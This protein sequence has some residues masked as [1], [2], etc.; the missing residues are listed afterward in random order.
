MSSQ[1]IVIVDD[2]QVNLSLFDALVRKLGSYEPHCFLDARE[3]L[4]WAKAHE[5]VLVIVDYMMPVLNGIEFIQQ[6]RATPGRSTV[7]ILMVTAN[8]LKEVRYRALNVGATDFLTKP[9]DRVEFMA[10][11]TNLLALSKAQHQLADR[12]EWLALE[13]R[14]A[15]AE[16]AQRELETVLRLSKAAEYRDPETGAHILRMA[17]YSQLIARGLGLSVEEQ[18]LILH[19]AP[20]HDIG[21]VGV[22]DAILLKPG[23]LTPEE[24]ELMK[25]HALYGFEI[26]KDSA[27]P[28]LQSGATIALGHHEKFDG[29]GYPQGLRGSAIP[30]QCRIV[31][32]ADVFDALTSSRPYKP[33]WTL[34]AARRHIQSQSGSHF[35]PSC[36]AVFFEH[37]DEVMEIRDRFRDDEEWPFVLTN[38]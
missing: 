26:L 22:V 15:T 12:A 36:V 4:A 6:L 20:L 14:K 34:E 30:L 7:P 1:Y 27:S 29:S 3:G 18:D 33:A 35:D 32:V 21:K 17:H 9:L 38:L 37:W 13:V 19:A 25:H 31:A 11:A 5:S 23:R 16:I 10:R 28:L 8:D 24:F 2:S